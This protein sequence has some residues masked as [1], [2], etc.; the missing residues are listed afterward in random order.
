MQP[1]L[2]FV[3][4][5]PKS[6]T[7]W[8]QLLLNAHPNICCHPEGLFQRFAQLLT[9]ACRKYNGGLLGRS[10]WFGSGFPQMQEAEFFE[11]LRFFIEQRMRRYAPETKALKW[12]GEKDPD[13]ASH[14]NLMMSNLFPDASYIHIIRDGRDQA[15]SAWWHYQRDEG[16]RRKMARHS[17]EQWALEEGKRWSTLI[18]SVRAARAATKVSY[19]EVLYERLLEEPATILKQVF[20]FLDVEATAG[21]ISACLQEGR[22]DKLSG[23]RQRGDEN[24]NSFFRKGEHGDWRNHMSAELAQRF[25]E[26]TKGLLEELGYRQKITRGSQ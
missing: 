8:L 7:T 24:R 4:G 1:K 17:W 13:H 19:H 21:I 26:E 2:F 12:I 18:R 14:V 20:D 3:I 22:F 10:K 5:V 6:G 9:V 23:G 25:D 15:V 11:L 16:I